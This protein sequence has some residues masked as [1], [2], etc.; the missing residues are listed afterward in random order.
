MSALVK[1]ELTITVVQN[2]LTHATVGM[3][4]PKTGATQDCTY[5]TLG[6]NTYHICSNSSRALLLLSV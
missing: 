1:L 6:E 5:L 2:T 4:T 3:L